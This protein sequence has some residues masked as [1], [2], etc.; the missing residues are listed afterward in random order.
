[1]NNYNKEIWKSIRGYENYQVSNYG[2][3]KSL[4]RIDSRNHFRAGMIKQASTD[5]YGYK[6][7]TLFREG[8]PKIFK[9]HRLVALAFIPNPHK[10]D[11]V[12]HKDENR[13]NNIVGNLEWCNAKYNSN[14]G[15]FSKH[16]SKALKQSKK[17]QAFNKVAGIPKRIKVE[18]RT[19]DGKLVKIWESISDTQKGG[20]DPSAIVK[21]C[22]GKQETSRGYKFQYAP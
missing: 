11:Q 18:Q 15:N 13:A 21:C 6:V 14:Y 8:Q 9:V 3:I 12:N 22:K 19:L 17:F 7:V 20:F 2:N 5:S 10:Y 1:M 16:L 4:D